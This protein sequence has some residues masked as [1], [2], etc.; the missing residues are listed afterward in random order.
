MNLVESAI[1][2]EEMIDLKSN[3]SGLLSVK[4]SFFRLDSYVDSCLNKF[5]RCDNGFTVLFNISLTFPTEDGMTVLASSGGDSS[6]TFGGFY[7]HQIRNYGENYLE[8]GVSTQTRLFQTKVYLKIKIKFLNN[9]KLY[10]FF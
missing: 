2:L 9:D 1:V 5:E 10:G 7:L 4:G 8:F 3:T 6:Y